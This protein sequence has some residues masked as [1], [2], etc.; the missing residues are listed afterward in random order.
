MRFSAA[1]LLSS[2]PILSFAIPTASPQYGGGPPSSWPEPPYGSPTASL[3][4]YYDK[5]CPSTTQPFATWLEQIDTLVSYAHYLYILQD[6]S[7]AY[8]TYAAENFTNH[9]PEVPGDG[10]A[11]VIEVQ[12]PM[13]KGGSVQIQRQFVGYNA[14]GTAY[15]VTYFRG[16]STYEGVGVIADIWRMIG[17]C[18][19]EHWDVA[20]GATLNTT[21]NPHPYF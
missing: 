2:L 3:A 5:G 4:E 11:I 12:T 16:V 19:V 14:S 21:S 18:L 10:T 15:G 1:L 7:T 13:L 6:V 20:E 8:T 9:A 17:T